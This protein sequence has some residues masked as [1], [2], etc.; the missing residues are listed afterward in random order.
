M[1]VVI[2]IG[3]V[4]GFLFLREMANGRAVGT[5]GAILAFIFLA[6]FIS[7]AFS[8]D[9]GVVIAIMLFLFVIFIIWGVIYSMQSIKEQEAK[10]AEEQAKIAANNR[11]IQQFECAVKKQLA[12][13]SGYIT[14]HDFYAW[15][16]EDCFCWCCKA[17]SADVP[18]FA[19]NRIS[20]DDILEFVHTYNS[21]QLY[22]M[23]GEEKCVLTL[24]GDDYSL[25]NKLLP[26][27]EHKRAEEIRHRNSITAMMKKTPHKAFAKL[28]DELD[29]G[30]FGIKNEMRKIRLFKQGYCPYKIAKWEN[31]QKVW[32]YITLEDLRNELSAD[33]T[34][35]DLAD[36]KSYPTKID[37]LEE[38]SKDIRTNKSERRKAVNA[39]IKDYIWKHYHEQI[40]AAGAE[41]SFQRWSY[42]FE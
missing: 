2:V 1:I 8:A 6:F 36:F 11:A 14:L 5:G 24:H 34:I 26:E 3:L 32:V 21:T 35:Y 7:Y 37:E 38:E 30:D 39:R 28:A 31:G 20:V 12:K 40:T 10:D 42:R 27:K 17:R 16:I 41:E 9:I 23:K 18:Q 25:L 22:Y 13:V 33:Y 4:L 29:D 15:V 19:V